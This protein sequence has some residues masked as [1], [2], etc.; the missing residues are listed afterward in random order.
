MRVSVLIALLGAPALVSAA[1]LQSVG[2]PA[3]A[4]QTVERYY[5]AID[6]GD[7]RAAYQTWDGNGA[8]SG[9]SYAAFRQGFAATARSRVVTG[10][11]VNGDAGMS[12]RWID[13]PVD[14]YATLKNGTRQHFRGRYTLHRVVEGTGA[15]VA[16]TRWHIA[17]AKLVAVR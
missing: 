1:P 6:R 2:S 8:A 13:V 3:A 14:V 9:K 4:K 10:T 11:P 5:A 17:S 15:P 16:K 7:F 12:Q